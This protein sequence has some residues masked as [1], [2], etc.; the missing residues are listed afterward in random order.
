MATTDTEARN[1]TIIQG[2]IDGL[3]EAIRLNW[4]EMERLDLLQVE[5]QVIRAKVA[6]LVQT[7]AG[8]L[9]NRRREQI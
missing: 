4:L 5:R 6:G 7:L 1:R 2:E 9:P 3:H 8:L